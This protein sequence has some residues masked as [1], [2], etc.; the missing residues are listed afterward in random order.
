MAEYNEGC[1]DYAGG[2]ESGQA[3]TY[4]ATAGGKTRTFH[5]FNEA[6][7]WAAENRT[8]GGEASVSTK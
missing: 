1:G 4:T 7:D 5:D 3:R 6:A 2:G 8:P